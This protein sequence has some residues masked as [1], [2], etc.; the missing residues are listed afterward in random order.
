MNSGWGMISR[1]MTTVNHVQGVC[2]Y[3][4]VN[5][6]QIC[7]CIIAAGWVDGFGGDVCFWG[8]GLGW[9]GEEVRGCYVTWLGWSDE[10]VVGFGNT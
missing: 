8:R 1:E 6:W 9:A 2:I 7:L 10:S 3:G 5:D 4:A